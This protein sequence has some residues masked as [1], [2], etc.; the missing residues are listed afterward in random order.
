[1]TKSWIELFEEANTPLLHKLGFDEMPWRAFLAE[2]G[3][4]HERLLDEYRTGQPSPDSVALAARLGVDPAQTSP[5]GL[6]DLLHPSRPAVF[7]ELTPTRQ[8]RD[9]IE[10]DDR[11][12]WASLARASGE[13]EEDV[14]ADRDEAFDEEMNR[15]EAY[16]LQALMQW[17]HH[18]RRIY[19]LDRDTTFAMAVTN[20]PDRPLDEIGFP[21]RSIYIRIPRGMMDIQTFDHNIVSTA[22]GLMLTCDRPAPGS[23]KERAIGITLCHSDRHVLGPVPTAAG[24]FAPDTPL[25]EVAAELARLLVADDVPENDDSTLLPALALNMAAYL[26]SDHPDLEPVPPKPRGPAAQS[27]RKRNRAESALGYIKVGRAEPPHARTAATTGRTQ[28]YQQEVVWH[29]K[30][31]WYG[32]GRKQS[33]RIEIQ[34]YTRGEDLPVRPGARPAKVQQA[35]PAPSPRRR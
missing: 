35:R 25:P 15:A 16:R 18:G 5:E 28:Q 20:P 22:D 10:E 3:R 1:M 4:L 11:A 19:V 8:I 26:T 33:R 13:R 29:V 31:Q 17:M 7:H 30:T 21:F 6:A 24:V 9:A 2:A 27:H 14:Y 12:Y 23:G 32:P 34:S